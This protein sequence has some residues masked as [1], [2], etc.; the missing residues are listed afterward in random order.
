MDIF[1][2]TAGCIEYCGNK[3]V[4]GTA[5]LHLLQW[6]RRWFSSTN[7]DLCLSVGSW[8]I[9][10]LSLRS[11]NIESKIL[12]CFYFYYFF[13]PYYLH[14]QADTSDCF[15]VVFLYIT[16]VCLSIC[17]SH[18]LCQPVSVGDTS[19]SKN[20]LKFVLEVYKSLQVQLLAGVN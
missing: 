9:T 1:W 5:K 18:F 2:S 19:V 15:F 20:T 12:C 7:I 8:M 16:S 17:L 11:N 4:Y 3:Q 14:K 10:A 6:L 13:F